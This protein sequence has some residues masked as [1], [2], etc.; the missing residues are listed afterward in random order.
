MSA[1]RRSM[2]M[3]LS[4]SGRS[5]GVLVRCGY[6]V[7][8]LILHWP[9]ESATAVLVDAAGAVINPQTVTLMRWPVGAESAL[10][11]GGYQIAP[12]PDPAEPWCNC[13]D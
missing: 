7:R 5:I 9:A 4:E 12:Y 11:R 6:A 10:R 3:V 13:A 1:L 8:P 2:A